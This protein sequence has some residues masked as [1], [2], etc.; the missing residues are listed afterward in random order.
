LDLFD[1]PEP[2][3]LFARGARDIRD[4]ISFLF[5]FA[6]D[7]SQPSQ[8]DGREHIDY[9]PSQAFTEFVRYHMKT[10]DGKSI[11][12]IRYRSSRNGRACVVLFCERENC[13]DVDEWNRKER[14]LRLQEG[15][16]G[17]LSEEQFREARD[18]IAKR[19]QDNE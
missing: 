6:K 2:P 4:T 1:L 15:S 14:I 3:G 9:V 19:R 11:D 18:R 12:G 10:R 8:R 7:L 16:L 5:Q 17:R 13:I